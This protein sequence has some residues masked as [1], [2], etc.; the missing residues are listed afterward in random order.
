MK[1]IGAI[2][3]DNTQHIT[4]VIIFVINNRKAFTKNTFSP[5]TN[6]NT[7]SYTNLEYGYRTP[8]AT[9]AEIFVH[10][11]GLSLTNIPQENKIV[12]AKPKKDALDNKMFLTHQMFLIKSVSY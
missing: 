6:P 2:K 4:I 10:L 7:D 12:I 3:I 8:K 9:K 11:A 5:N 1:P